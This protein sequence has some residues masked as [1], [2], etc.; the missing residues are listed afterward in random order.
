MRA[1]GVLHEA[2]ARIPRHF[3]AVIMARLFISHLLYEG[4][5]LLY[6]RFLYI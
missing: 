5:F 4:Q 6:R 3:S 1:D 2:A